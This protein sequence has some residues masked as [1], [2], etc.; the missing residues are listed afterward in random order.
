MRLQNNVMEYVH[1]K[2]IEDIKEGLLELAENEKITKSISI[3]HFIMWS[4]SQTEK[5]VLIVNQLIIT[6]KDLNI[7]TPTD[8]EEG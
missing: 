8:I 6:L 2:N 7:I 3:G 5:E 4:F 1:S